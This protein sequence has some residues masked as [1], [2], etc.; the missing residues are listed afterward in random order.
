LLASSQDGHCAMIAA[1]A[2]QRAGSQSVFARAGT[3]P[4]TSTMT[5]AATNRFMLSSPFVIRS[6]SFD[7]PAVFRSRLIAPREAVKAKNERSDASQSC[8]PQVP[9][10]LDEGTR[11]SC[12]L[13]VTVQSAARGQRAPPRH[14]RV[15]RLTALRALV[16]HGPE[17][18][19]GQG[20]TEPGEA[21]PVAST[22]AGR[23][24]RLLARV[25]PALTLANRTPCAPPQPG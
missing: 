12:E 16:P 13:V 19:R 14:D 1:C 2:A 7:S 18:E 10:S 21:D 5:A 22:E 20:T 8:V 11:G 6:A 17:R 9:V 23:E 3:T 24:G 25:Q 15:S 4:Q